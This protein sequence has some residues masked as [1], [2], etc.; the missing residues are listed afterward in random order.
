MAQSHF[1]AS[2]RGFLTALAAGAALHR[3]HF[4]N[5]AETDP[6]LAQVLANTISYVL[7]SP[8]PN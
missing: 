5:A 6:R 7:V 1:N 4:L 8:T 3:P 2:R